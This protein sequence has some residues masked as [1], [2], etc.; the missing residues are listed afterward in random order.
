MNTF[1]T[2]TE[3][4][5][6]LVINAIEI[7]TSKK[8]QFTSTDKKTFTI[9]NVTVRVESH[10]FIVKSES[11]EISFIKNKDLLNFILVKSTQQKGLYRL[12]DRCLT[13]TQISLQA[14]KHITRLCNS[15][16]FGTSKK[17]LYE[18]ILYTDNK[19][20]ELSEMF[21]VNEKLIREIR[22]VNRKA[23]VI[24]IINELM[25]NPAVDVAA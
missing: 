19:P 21:G 12:R 3:K 25:T 23:I 9:N 13:L 14:Q 22:R 11:I 8:V 20:S 10:E 5:S 1:N 7:I 4:D 17:D 6:F 24:S 2:K 16:L 15:E 18:N